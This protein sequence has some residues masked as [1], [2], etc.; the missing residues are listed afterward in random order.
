MANNIITQLRAQRKQY[1]TTEQKLIDFIVNHVSE[2]REANIQE[3]S[4]LSG[5]STATISRFVK[6]IGLESFREF[7]VSLASA[8]TQMATSVDLFGEIA[9][10]DDTIAVAQKV[11]GGAENA[12]AATVSNLTATQLEEATLALISARRVGF[13]G[14]GGSSIVA[15][16]AYHKFLRTPIDVIAHPDYDVQ[17]MQA[18]KLNSNDTAVVISHSGRNKDTLLIAKKL[19]EQHVK[20]IA[21]TSFKDSP[22]AKLA[23]MVFLSLAEEVNFRSESMSSLIAQLTIIDTLF[24]LVGSH[25]SQDTQS[26]VDTMRDVIEETRS[27]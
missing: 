11:F 4:E 20:I 13:F 17:L 24:T 19:H 21:V 3:M 9:D 26:V 7:S 1:N 5:V 15:F 6:K 23:N 10:T 2:A 14:I 16:N 25:L 12:L 22:L 18:V 27:H 8:A